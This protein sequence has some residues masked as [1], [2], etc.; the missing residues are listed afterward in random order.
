MFVRSILVPTASRSNLH[1]I[2]TQVATA[3]AQIRERTH[4]FSSIP[5]VETISASYALSSW[6]AFVQLV[7]SCIALC[8]CVVKMLDGCGIMCVCVVFLV[9]FG[10]SCHHVDQLPYTDC[11]LSR[12]KIPH[13]IVSFILWFSLVLAL[14]HTLTFTSRAS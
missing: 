13:A 5:S 9:Y 3:Y 8:L 1:R 14:T 7:Y 6:F 10:W 11:T 12:E 2:E 4:E